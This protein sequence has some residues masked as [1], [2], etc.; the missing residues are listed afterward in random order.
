MVLVLHTNYT[1]QLYLCTVK[2]PYRAGNVKLHCVP[3][4]LGTHVGGLR[5]ENNSA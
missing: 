2:Y 4:V 1:G 3:F 5:V